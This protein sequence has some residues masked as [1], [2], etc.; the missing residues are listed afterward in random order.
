ME[1]SGDFLT[2]IQTVFDTVR[3]S[4]TFSFLVGF[5]ALYSI[6]LFFDIVLLF[7][8]RPIG[9]DIKKGW[10]GSKE[11]PLA[12]PR[13]LAREWR[14][15]ESQL[16]SSA[17]NAGKVAILRA[18]EFADRM[19][20]ETGYA[21]KSFGERLDGIPDRHFS[22]LAGL[23]EA[24][25]IRNKIVLDRSFVL[26]RLEAKRVLKLYRAFLEEAEILV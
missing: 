1:F 11:R 4:A 9:G 18:D 2:T 25:E 6:V 16:D 5:L 8:L 22:K 17:P 20:S 10:F 24:H 14:A 12:S 15:I 19:L 7:A 23:R 26:D 13:R 3:S 21:G